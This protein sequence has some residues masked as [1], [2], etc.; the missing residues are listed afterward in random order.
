M[1]PGPRD[2]ASDAAITNLSGG[3]RD[4]AALHTKKSTYARSRVMRPSNSLNYAYEPEEEPITH[5]R[6][7]NAH[8]R[9]SA[10]LA[11]IFELWENGGVG[12]EALQQYGI[13]V[14]ERER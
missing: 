8:Q 3:R 5:P 9:R 12:G 11:A 10:E 13:Y 2:D 6:G 4:R 14:G 1:M 7:P